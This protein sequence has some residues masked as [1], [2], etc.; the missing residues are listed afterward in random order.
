[1]FTGLGDIVIP[2]IFLALLLRF[3]RRVSETSSLR[4]GKV[5]QQQSGGDQKT[6]MYF[7]VTLCAYA[8]GLVL[9][10]GVMH[11]YGFI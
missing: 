2:G 7:A 5:R 9:T 6:R 4:D 8:A 3:D 1:L 10:I 11:W